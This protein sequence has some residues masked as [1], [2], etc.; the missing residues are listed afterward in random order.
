MT[1]YHGWLELFFAVGGF[2]LGAVLAWAAMRNSQRNRAN[3]PIT[4]AAT[5]EEYQHPDSYNPEKFRA[6]L[7]PKR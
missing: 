7:H 1:Q 3:D 2:A 4:E 5:R 6:Q